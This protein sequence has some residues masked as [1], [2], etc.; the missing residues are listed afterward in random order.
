MNDLITNIGKS[1]I[2]HGKYN[3]RIYL[4]KLD[5]EDIP[6]IIYDLEKLA[7]SEDYSKIIAKVP[8]FAKDIFMGNG[9][10]V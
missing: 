6:D 4:M 2:H 8:A 5:S 1:I 9:Y 3:D 7:S 10:I